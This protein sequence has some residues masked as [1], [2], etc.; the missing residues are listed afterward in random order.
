MKCSGGFTLVELL[1]VI[2]IIGL[3]VALL[4]PSI[5]ATRESGRRASCTNNLKQWGLAMQSHHDALRRLPYGTSRTNPQG[6][7]ASVPVPPNPPAGSVPRRTFIIAL[8][9]YLEATALASAYN[10][11]ELFNT[12]TN[13]PLCN[14]PLG[15]YYCPSDRPGAKAGGNNNTNVRAVNYIINWGTSTYSGAGRR[16]P[17]GWLGGWTWH[18]QLPY[19][20]RFADITDGT[21]KTLLMSEVALPPQDSVIDTRPHR[22]NDVGSPG[23]MTRITPNSSVPDDIEDCDPYLPCRVSGRG[24]MSLAARSRHPGGVVIALCDGSV[25]FVTDA[26]NIGTWQA[27]STMNQGDAVGEY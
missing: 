4:L 2:A 10:Y 26:V 24:A 11:D 19:R 9:P 1:V 22:F 27:L 7:E 21:S 3:L 12:A 6:L 8:W 13:R 17:F 16:A 15:V 20:T 25:R 23:F 18:N 14:T 5:Q